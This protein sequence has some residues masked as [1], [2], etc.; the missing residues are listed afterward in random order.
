MSRV[1]TH[2][3]I[4]AVGGLALARLVGPQA[5]PFDVSASLGPNS[6]TLVF[7]GGSALLATL[8]DIDEPNSWIGQRVRWILSVLAGLLLGWAGWLLAP[9]DVGASIAQQ[10]RIVTPLRPFVGA[11]VGFMVGALLVGPWLSYEVLRGAQDMFGGHRRMTHSLIT[12]AIL[13]AG[14]II[15]WFAILPALA[16][17]IA[18]LLWGQ[19]LHLVG[20][21]V[22]PGGVPLF[23]PMQAKP[24]KLPYPIA[25]WGEPSIAVASLLLGVWLV[26][27]QL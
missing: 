3:L 6:H 27:A 21:V 25:V 19:L 1:G 26:G 22:T 4:G 24:I 12:S 5:L 8:A 23:W 7:A 15:L 13:A 20:D 16:L 18:A 2:M 14:G 11:G 10:V 9:T 17:I